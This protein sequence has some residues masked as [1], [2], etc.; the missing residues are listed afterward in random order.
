MIRKFIL[1]LIILIATVLHSNVFGQFVNIQ[2]NNEFAGGSIST[3]Q[4]PVISFETSFDSGFIYYTLDGSEPSVNS[5]KSARYSG[6]FILTDSTDIN[7]I[8]YSSDYSEK[9]YAEPVSIE[10]LETFRLNIEIEGGGKI[11][12]DPEKE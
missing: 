10:I 12:K 5:N 1:T 9:A 3:G 6:P 8:V 7:A 2:V 4:K 11:Q